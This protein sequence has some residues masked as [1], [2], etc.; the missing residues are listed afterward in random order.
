MMSTSFGRVAHR[1]SNSVIGL[2]NV[3]IQSNVNSFGAYAMSGLGAPAKVEEL[4]TFSA[5]NGHEHDPAHLRQP[6]IG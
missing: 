2:G 6:R 3:V 5:V 1:H 4:C